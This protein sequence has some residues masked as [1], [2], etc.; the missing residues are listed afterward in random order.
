MTTL[1]A[2]TFGSLSLAELEG[3]EAHYMDKYAL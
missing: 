1:G 2:D 3:V